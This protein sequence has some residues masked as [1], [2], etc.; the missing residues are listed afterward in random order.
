MASNPERRRLLEQII[1]ES[2]IVTRNWLMEEASLDKHAIDNLV[3]S[4]QLKLLW[5]GLY[6]RGS[7]LL[8]W[9]SMVYTLQTVMKT[10]YVVG[11]LSALELKGF[12]H[13]IPVSQ[14]ETIRLYG[15]DKLPLWTNELSENIAFIRHTRNEL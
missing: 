4:E 13:Y 15:N 2:M 8:S 7:I 3:K 11:G 1:P 10:D 14:K 12:S 5:K 9:Q 6:T